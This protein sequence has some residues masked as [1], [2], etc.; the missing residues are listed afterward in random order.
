MVK[1]IYGRYADYQKLAAKPEDNLYFITDTHQIYKGSTLVADCNIRFVNVQPTAGNSQPN[2]LY[3][4][5]SEDNKVTL[6]TKVGDSV[7]QVGGGEATEIAAGVIKL[8]NFVEGTI[9]TT[10]D[11]ATDEQLPTAKTVADAV[12][13]VKNDLT[14]AL[15][16]Y[17]GAFVE[18]SAGAHSDAG[19]V[20]TFT[21]KDGKTKD[22][23]VADLFLKSASYDASTHKL[24]LTVQGSETPVEVD[25]SDLVGASF[26]D[27]IVGSDEVFTVELG[28]DGTLGGFKT[29]DTIAKDTSLETVVKKLLMKQVAPNYTQPSVGINNNGG[30][31]AGAYEVGTSIT[32][33]LRAT[34]TQN[35][36]GALTSYQFKKNGT[37]VGDAS[38]S[39]PATV[40]KLLMKQVAPNYTQ[41]SVGINNNGGTAAGAYE[42]GTSITPKLRATFTQNDAGALTS[43]QFKKNGTNVGDASTS[44]PATYEETAF[45]L[46]EANVT[47]TAT[48]TYAE[49]AIK[50]DNLGQPYP[51][52]HIAAGSK[53]TH[54][55]TISYYRQGY[56]MGSST[57]TATPNSDTIRSLTSKKGS[58]YSAGTFKFTVPVGAAQVII[59]CPANKTGVTKI[60]NESALNA[61]VTATF[62]KVKNG[63]DVEGANKFAAANYNVWTFTPPEAYGNTATL[64]VTLG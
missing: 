1:F 34:F 23:T 13:K 9:V 25:L 12:S 26:S 24:A 60:L 49:G 48:A 46:G 37:N 3:I 42:V 45:T 30:T 51:N 10:L 63:V 31:A 53:T 35:D 27:V 43:Y 17:D 57:S 47:Y 55:Y 14:T 64:A 4:Y 52:G 7:I 40:K 8:S 6:W 5:T 32:P 18:V 19:T 56:F 11:G 2:L 39:A 59:A 15:A 33:K 54:N 16:G 36:A 61:D 50:N 20:L 29:G 62:K 44:A 22:V 28:T 38:T 41:P 21:T 58:A